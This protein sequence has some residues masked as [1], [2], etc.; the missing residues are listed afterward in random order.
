MRVPSGRSDCRGFSIAMFDQGLFR[1]YVVPA[2][3][4]VAL[5]SALIIAAV[6]G[7]YDGAALVEEVRSE[8]VRTR[9]AEVDLGTYR[10]TMPRDNATNTFTELEL[11]IFGTAPSY[12][13]P[14]IESRLT[15]E[16]Y[17]LRHEM[18]VAV[19]VSTSEELADPELTQLRARIERVV[20][21]VLGESPIQAVG[22]YQLRLHY[23]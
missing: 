7:C 4:L 9:L 21:D 23:R 3:Y 5:P 15:S 11:H 13:V 2:R 12:H 20:N 19:R 8:A 17:R 6:S 18:L 1:M 14:R 16:G 10:V 22:F